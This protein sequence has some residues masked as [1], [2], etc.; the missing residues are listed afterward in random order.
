MA[1]GTYYDW[2]YNNAGQ[3]GNG[4]T[5]NSDTPVRVNLPAKAEQVSL[6]RKSAENGQTVAIL[7]DGSL[8]A[9][10]QGPNWADWRWK[11]CEQNCSNPG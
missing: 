10:G 8:W 7:T 4:T 3:L 9:W 11:G 6:G 2:G 5:T 1:D